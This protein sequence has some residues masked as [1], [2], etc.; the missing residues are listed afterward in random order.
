MS[1]S[2]S[3]HSTS[4]RSRGVDVVLGFRCWR[5]VAINRRS[6]TTPVGRQPRV[7]DACNRS[8]HAYH[9][10]D[11]RTINTPCFRSRRELCVLAACGCM[12]VLCSAPCGPLLIYPARLGATTAVVSQPGPPPPLDRLPVKTASRQNSPGE[13]L[14]RPPVCLSVAFPPLITTR[15]RSVRAPVGV[16]CLQLPWCG[17]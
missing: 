2:E 12:S 11:T 15:L 14:E 16:C 6:F 8:M 5:S 9:S 3:I 4:P 13:T 10:R 7:V 17:C 1:D